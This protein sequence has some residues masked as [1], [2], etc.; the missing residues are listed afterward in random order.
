MGF[1][2]LAFIV[3]MKVISEFDTSRLLKAKSFPELI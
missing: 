3:Q 2:Q 1:G